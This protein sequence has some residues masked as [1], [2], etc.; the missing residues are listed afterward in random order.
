MKTGTLHH[1]FYVGRSEFSVLY[2]HTDDSHSGVF[3]F[4]L[5]RFVLVVGVIF[6]C[7]RVYPE[8]GG[9]LPYICLI[10]ICAAPKVFA[11]FWSENGYRLCLFCLNSVLVFEGIGKCLDVFVA[12]T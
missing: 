9:L 5:Y 4:L 6:W 8:G 7:E 11:L 1:V 2:S 10:D 12:L 3:C